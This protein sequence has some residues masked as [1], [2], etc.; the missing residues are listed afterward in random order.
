MP[1]S[2]EVLWSSNCN[3]YV[4]AVVPMPTFPSLDIVKTGAEVVPTLKM[5]EE[6]E[7]PIV[8]LFPDKDCKFIALPLSNIG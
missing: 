3:L 6:V 4:G 7:V 5:P 1:K 2:A 8:T